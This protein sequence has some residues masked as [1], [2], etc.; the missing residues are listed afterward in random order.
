M[1]DPKKEPPSPYLDEEE[2]NKTAKEN[3]VDAIHPVYGFLA[4]N[5]HFAKRCRE[6]G[7][8][9]VGPT[10]ETMKDLGDK[11]R[12]KEIAE[13]VKVSTIRDSEID[14]SSKE[15]LHSEAE[16]IG[17]PI[18]VKAVAGG[19]GG[20]MRIVRSA[21]DLNSAYEEESRE[22]KTA[23]GDDTIFLEK[24]IEDTKHIEAPVVSDQ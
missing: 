2:I 20:G 8:I 4:E 21:D 11:V 15:I 23:F 13:Q 22:A 3:G 9:F 24:L 16:K 19:G 12:A 17:Y 6:E 14:L 1:I 18:M 7:I 10:P 5:V